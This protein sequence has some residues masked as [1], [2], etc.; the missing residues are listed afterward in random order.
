MNLA[1]FF[2]V[3]TATASSAARPYFGN[4]HYERLRQPEQPLEIY[5]FEVCPYCRIAREALSALSLDPIVFPCP[6]GGRLFREKVKREGGRYQFPYLVD[7][8]TGVDMYESADIVEY[9][10][11]EYGNGQAPWFLRQR[12]FAVSTSM[13]ASAFR[14]G[15]GRHAVASRQPEKLLELYSY[16]GSPFCRIAREALCELELPYRLRN[17]PRRS[18]DRA[19]YVAISGK[20]QVP[21]LLDPNTAVQMF[22]SADIR[23]YL[24]ETYAIVGAAN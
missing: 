13:L 3:S 20:M 21:F 24:Y 12:A 8:N 9:L 11:S 23:R 1:R 17:V 19:D 22:E 10:F 2:D 18:P 7:P 16:E 14:P 4:I 6:Q 5:E 15:R